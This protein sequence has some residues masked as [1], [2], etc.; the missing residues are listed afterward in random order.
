[1]HKADRRSAPAMQDKRSVVV[2]EEDE[3]DAWLSG[4]KAEA[5]ALVRLAPVEIF[6]AGPE[7]EASA[8]DGSPENGPG[9]S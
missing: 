1:M 5:S 8:F 3:W 4:T 7:S 6:I 9:G 2:L